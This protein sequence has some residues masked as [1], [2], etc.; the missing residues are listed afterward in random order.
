M[1]KSLSLIVPVLVMVGFLAAQSYPAKKTAAT[2]NKQPVFGGA[3]KLCPW[4][5]L[6]DA[7]KSAMQNYGYD[8]QICHNCNAEDSPRIVAQARM[9]PPYKV[10]PNV[11]VDAAPPNAPDLGPIDFGATGG[12]FLCDAYHAAGRYSKD[13]PMTNLRLLANI[14]GG[15]TYLIV[16]A[17][18]GTGIT[19]LSQARAKRWPLRVYAQ[20]NNKMVDEVLAHYG[21]SAKEIEEAGGFVGGSSPDASTAPDPKS[22]DMII[23]TGGWV[24]TMPESRTWTD[25]VQKNDWN[26]LSLPEP[27][28]AK[29]AQDFKAEREIVPFGW[30][31][32]IDR[33]IPS[34]S[35]S[36]LGTA[37][38]ARTDFPESVAY[39]VAKA[40]NEHQ[41][42]LLR[43]NQRFFYD[44][45]KV[46]QICDVP[47]HPGAARYY[48]EV[49]YMK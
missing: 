47:L 24:G 14:Q 10:D 28:L 45:H 36:S 33:A 29:L 43:T 9:P 4:G 1:K 30:L 44:V 26:F 8:V 48:K 20:R 34:V 25:V 41:D 38:Y 27:L 32:G 42:R 15:P 17:R 40:L 11:S 39:D 13:K 49:G 19:D 16:A 7:V 2:A 46:C 12:A 3:C 31:P 21:L 35:M 18:V 22:Y 6:G 37:V 5:A 23:Q